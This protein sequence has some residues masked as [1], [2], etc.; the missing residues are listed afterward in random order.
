L[1]ISLLVNFF[2]GLP[3][4]LLMNTTLMLEV[5]HDAHASIGERSGER[6]QY[7]EHS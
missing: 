6:E 3:P 5:E 7:H 1:L 4:L 2:D